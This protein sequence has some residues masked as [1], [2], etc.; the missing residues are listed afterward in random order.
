MTNED[1]AAI[2]DALARLRLESGLP[3][4]FGGALTGTDRLQITEFIGA[5]SGTMRGLRVESGS[6][7]GGKAMA[8]RRPVIVNDYARAE[9]ITHDYDEAVVGEGIRTMVGVPVVV[10]RS[11]RAVLYGA[12]R[13]NVSV[14]DRV[15]DSVITAGR[16]LEQDLAVRDAFEAQSPAVEAFPKA[17]L[18]AAAV[19]EQ[20]FELA[21]RVDDEQ[22]Q[23][24]LLRLLKGLPT[25]D[26]IEILTRS[27]LS[28]RE[29]EVLMHVAVGRTNA[30]IGEQMGVGAETVKSY[31]R[32]A[33]RKLDVNNRI[34]AVVA[35]RRGGLL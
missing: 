5:Q 14:G 29:T 8:L 22:I 25:P 27:P 2:R 21:G 7:L 18:D 28:P 13:T 3:M 32:T 4:L 16:V 34:E 20:L 33:M 6:G 9:A 10:G 30:V 12:L 24:Q 35:A 26:Q 11:V 23:G 1:R 17:G 31:L 15:V 19:R